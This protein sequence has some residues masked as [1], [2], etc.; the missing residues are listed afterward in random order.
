MIKLIKRQTPNPKAIKDVLGVLRFGLAGGMGIGPPQFGVGAAHSQGDA[1][2]HTIP[3]LIKNGRNKSLNAASAKNPPTGVTI[4]TT[5]GNASG[6]TGKPMTVPKPRGS[7]KNESKIKAMEYPRQAFNIFLWASQ[8]STV[9]PSDITART[10]QFVVI[11]SIYAF[12]LAVISGTN[13]CAKNPKMA[14]K[15]DTIIIKR[16]IL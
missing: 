6:R 2:W 10:M 12:I 8:K 5:R 1:S 11:R 14:T 13:A 7:R 3:T 16:E 4:R 15:T 9:N